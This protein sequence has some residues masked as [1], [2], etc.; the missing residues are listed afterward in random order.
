MRVEVH[1]DTSYQA[2]LKAQ[3]VLKVKDKQRPNIT[4]LLAEKNSEQVT[5]NTAII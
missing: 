3:Q 1:A 5:H 2:Q 4:V